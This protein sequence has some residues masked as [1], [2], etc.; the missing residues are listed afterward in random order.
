MTVVAVICEYNLF[1]N[2]HAR[3]LTQI[4][5]Q[6]GEETVILSLMSG[7]FTQRG[8]FAATD[9][10][11]RAHAALLGGSDLTLE[12]PM[13]YCCGVAEQFALGAVQLL[14]ALSVVDVLAFGSECG[15]VERLSAIAQNRRSDSYQAA[16]TKAL[17]EAPADESYLKTANRVYDMLFGPA[18]LGANDTLAVEYLC[19]LQRINSTITPYTCKREGRETATQARRI[20]QKEGPAGLTEMVP[21]A[22]LPVFEKAERSLPQLAQSAVLWRLR[23]ADPVALASLA[24][25]NIDLAHLLVKQAEQ[26]NSLSDFYDRCVSKKYTRARIRRCSLYA[27][28]DITKNDFAMRPSYTLLLSANARG[29]ALLRTVKKCSRIPVYTKGAKAQTPLNGRADA[30]YTLSLEGAKSSGAILRK[31]PVLLFD[32]E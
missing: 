2:G 10:Y 13:P 3:L 7:H 9:K 19:A 8:L 27:M 16:L 20:F 24:D 31:N 15:D 30:L 1:H 5:R 22:V 26:A 21:A 18:P 32:D 29:R 12:L 11:T 25:F 14:D 23:T 6:F 17:A 28:L 4:R